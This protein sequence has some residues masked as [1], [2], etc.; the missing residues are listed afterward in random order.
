MLST[1]E[2]HDRGGT[3]APQ[4]RA[5]GAISGSKQIAQ[6]D[7]ERWVNSKTRAIDSVGTRGNDRRIGTELRDS[8]GDY[9]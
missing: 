3:N 7:M 1:H 8:D 2:R 6:V 9:E 4:G 5:T